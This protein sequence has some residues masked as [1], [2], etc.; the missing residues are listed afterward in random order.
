M[1]PVFLR[2]KPTFE[3][4]FFGSVLLCVME[5]VFTGGC[6]FPGLVS[7]CLAGSGF[8]ACTSCEGSGVGFTTGAGSGAVAAAAAAGGVKVFCAARGWIET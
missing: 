6:F 3:S 7:G 1:R 5:A 8:G 2:I 4:S